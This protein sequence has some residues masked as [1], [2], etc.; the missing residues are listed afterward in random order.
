VLGFVDPNGTYYDLLNSNFDCE[1]D[2]GITLVFENSTSKQDKS[3][4]WNELYEVMA[5]YLL[6]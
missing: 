4:K 3:S 2:N 5:N 6:V 1:H